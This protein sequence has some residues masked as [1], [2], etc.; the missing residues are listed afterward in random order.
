[1]DMFRNWNIGLA[2]DDLSDVETTQL[3]ELQEI[4]LSGTTKTLYK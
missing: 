1:M 3:C 4:L 2:K